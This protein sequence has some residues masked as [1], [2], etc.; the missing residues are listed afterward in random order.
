MEIKGLTSWAKSKILSLRSSESLFYSSAN[1]VFDSLINS[2]WT[3]LRNIFQQQ[4]VLRSFY[5]TCDKCESNMAL[6]ILVIK[7]KILKQR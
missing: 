5:N 2:L 1:F 4:N 3:A 7:K 6:R